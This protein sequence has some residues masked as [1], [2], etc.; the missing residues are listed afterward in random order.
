MLEQKLLGIIRYGSEVT[1]PL[2]FEKWQEPL[3]SKSRKRAIANP[4]KIFA[5][6]GS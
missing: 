4:G 1:I 6:S 5:L 3:N 2:A